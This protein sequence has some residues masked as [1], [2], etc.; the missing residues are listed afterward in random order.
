MGGALRARDVVGKVALGVLVGGALAR[1][2]GAL[3][4]KHHLLASLPGPDARTLSAKGHE[5]ELKKVG[6][7]HRTHSGLI[8]RLQG[9][10]NR[11]TL[12]P[13]MYTVSQAG[14]LCKYLLQLHARHGPVVRLVLG[15]EVFVSVCDTKVGTPRLE[16]MVDFECGA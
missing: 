13:C 5:E 16:E 6:L 1:L 9:G 12:A 15:G 7:G 10:S 8:D 14:G 4:R 2:L 11:Q 3:Y